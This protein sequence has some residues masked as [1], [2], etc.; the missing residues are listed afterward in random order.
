[1]SSAR[2]MV[3]MLVVLGMSVVPP[4]AKRAFARHGHPGSSSADEAQVR[5]LLSKLAAAAGVPEPEERTDADL[6]YEAMLRWNGEPPGSA[7]VDRLIDSSKKEAARTKKATQEK[8][9]KM[10][11]K[12]PFADDPSKLIPV[13]QEDRDLLDQYSKSNRRSEARA[14]REAREPRDPRESEVTRLRREL[15]AARA[16]AEEA[17]AENERIRRRAETM[18]Q[19][20]ACVADAS[21]SE[22]RKRRRASSSSFHSRQS[23]GTRSQQIAL[24]STAP[25]QSFE[26]PAPAPVAP[27]S[28]P[29][30]GIII[31]PL[32]SPPAQTPAVDGVHHR[33][34]RSR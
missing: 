29:E 23:D 31:T 1:M 3:S 32:P 5:E 4:T 15:A 20:Q 10:F 18:S 25:V 9:R 12:D 34:S 17:R 14:S 27:A 33:N 28:V 22:V 6:M 7:A 21:T 24:A 26:A 19:R 16:E 2:L 8:I 11:W 30:H 13:R